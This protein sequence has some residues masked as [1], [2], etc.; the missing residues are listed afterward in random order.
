M[1]ALIDTN[2]L[3]FDTFEDSEFHRQASD[4]LNSLTNWYLPDIVFHEMMWFFRSRTIDQLK[5]RLK[6]EEY[7][8]NEKC[9]FSSC[10]PDDIRFAIDMKSYANYNDHLILSLAKRLELPLFTFDQELE[11]TAKKN[12]VRIVKKRATTI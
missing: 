6:I 10:T 12:A 3:I 2:V 1:S 9:V 5:A 4:G 8:T 7:L 11:K